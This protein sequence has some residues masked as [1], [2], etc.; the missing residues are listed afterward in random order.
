LGFKEG[1]PLPVGK[2]GK[3]SRSLNEIL[4]ECEGLPSPGKEP[5]G[6][7]KELDKSRGKRGSEIDFGFNDKFVKDLDGSSEKFG[8]DH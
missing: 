7:G 6:C 4:E 5:H 2:S 3:Q 1:C 8:S